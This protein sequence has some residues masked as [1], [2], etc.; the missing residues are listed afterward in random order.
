MMIDRLD[1]VEKR[2]DEL[3][4]KISDPEVISRQEEWRKLTKE[5]ASLEELVSCY[6]EYK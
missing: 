6:R 2:Y 3:T 4:R 1:E 5:H